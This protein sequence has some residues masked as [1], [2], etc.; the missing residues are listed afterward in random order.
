MNSIKIGNSNIKLS[1]IAFGAWAIGGWL[2][3]GANKKDALNAISKAIE[4]GITTIDT[5]PVY[6]FGQSEE[7]TGKAIKGKRDKLQILTKFGLIWASGKG[8]F[9][10]STKDNSGNDV[11]VFKYASKKSV[12]K[13]C[14][15]SLKRLRIDYIDI[16]QIHWPDPSTPLEETMEAMNILKE[17]GKILAAGVC[18]YSSDLLDSARKY[19]DIVSDQVPYSMLRREI[20]T[21]LVPYCI[22][23]NVGILAYSPLQRGILTGKFKPDHKFNEGDNRA[24]LPWYKKDNLIKINNFL[25][26]LKPLAAQKDASLS[27]LVLRWTLQQPGISCVLAGA[28]NPQQIEENAGALKF[29]ITDEEISEMNEK[30]KFLNGEIRI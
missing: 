4:L 18:N 3:G 29:I 21:D 30:I 5:A 24:D 13:E 11:N 27:Q 8:Q 19:I 14:E 16:L 20:E 23:N 2:W 10:F 22:S 9:Y 12:I 25:E 26:E 15:V 17:Q 6:G 7:I 1:P 28:R